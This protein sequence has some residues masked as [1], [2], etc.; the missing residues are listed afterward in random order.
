MF[1]VLRDTRC[2]IVPST[3]TGD[4]HLR[5]RSKFEA[6]CS[7]NH[8]LQLKMWPK[9]V[10]LTPDW[11]NN[12]TGVTRSP[13]RCTFWRISIIHCNFDSPGSSVCRMRQC[14]RCKFR[15]RVGSFLS[16]LLLSAVPLHCGTEYSEGRTVRL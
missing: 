2:H 6:K 1:D 13:I 9:N 5:V 7:G 4:P 10:P 8:D 12:S 3:P 15:G 11:K 16:R 14:T